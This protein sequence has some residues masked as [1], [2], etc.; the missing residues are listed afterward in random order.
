MFET[1]AEWTWWVV[2]RPY[3][4][5]AST[6]VGIG[7]HSPLPAFQ[8]RARPQRSQNIEITI[9][10]R[11]QQAMNT[12]RARE[13]G[14]AACPFRRGARMR[15]IRRAGGSS[16]VKNS[17]T[18]ASLADVLELENRAWHWAAVG[19]SLLQHAAIS[20]ADPPR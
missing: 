4:V 20:P 13:P 11:A 10:T 5:Y 8:S 17:F 9:A 7:R 12:A 6:P 14:P 2:P 3:V 19:G 15:R 1:G 18:G 16:R